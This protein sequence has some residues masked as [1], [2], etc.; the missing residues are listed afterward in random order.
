MT[1]SNFTSDSI[2]EVCGRIVPSYTASTV[3]GAI[4]NLFKISFIERGVLDSK[5]KTS[6]WLSTSMRIPL[7]HTSQTY[8]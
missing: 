8:F 5:V 1:S 6:P 7:R 4:S 3:D 2:I